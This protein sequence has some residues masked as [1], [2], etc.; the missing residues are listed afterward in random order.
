MVAYAS[1]GCKNFLKRYG[2]KFR[3]NY[4]QGKNVAIIER[5]SV[6]KGEVIT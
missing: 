4:F 6:V 2:E 5:I 3:E 1:L